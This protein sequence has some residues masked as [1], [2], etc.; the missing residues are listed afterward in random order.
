MLAPKK[1]RP[2]PSER[3]VEDRGADKEDKA[4]AA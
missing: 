4:A 3:C 2:I 1:K